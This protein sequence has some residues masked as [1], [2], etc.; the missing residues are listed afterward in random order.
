MIEQ[1]PETA[2]PRGQRRLAPD[3]EAVIRWGL[4]V[5]PGFDR[6]LMRFAATPDHAVFPSEIFPWV[7]ELEGCVP[8]SGVRARSP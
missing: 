8:G 2:E 5:L 4:R 7:R 6:L 1:Q 3:R